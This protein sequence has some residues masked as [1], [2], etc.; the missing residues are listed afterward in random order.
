MLSFFI[1]Q[2]FLLLSSFT[3]S[4]Y[5]A[6]SLVNK[7][8][9]TS[10]NYTD[11]STFQSN[12]NKFLS[13]IPEKTVNNDWF[14]NDTIGKYPNQVYG[15]GMC[16]YDETDSDSCM[17]CL[18]DAALNITKLCPYSTNAALWNWECFIIYSN[19]NFFSVESTSS[20]FIVY[21]TVNASNPETYKQVLGDLMDKL[22][23]D[24]ASSP[25][26]VAV[27]EANFTMFKKVYGLVECTRDLSA[28]QCQKCLRIDI[29]WIPD[30]CKVGIGCRIFGP[31][32]HLR[33][34]TT[35]FYRPI[36]PPAPPPAPAPPP[37][38]SL[39][40]VE[41]VDPK[42]KTKSTTIYAIIGAACTIPLILLVVGVFLWIRRERRKIDTDETRNHSIKSNSAQSNE[43]NFQ[44]G[45]ELIIF[46]FNT[47][48][49]ATDNFSKE[50]KLGVGGFGVV[51]KGTLQN[52][53][54]LAVKRLS[55]T[56]DQGMGELR[57]EI[58]LLGRLKHRN[59]VKVIGC[60]IQKNEC[61][62]C[63]E[64]LRNSSLDKILFENDLRRRRE[65]NWKMRFNIIEGICRGLVYLHVESGA[66]II[67]RDL[68]ASNILLDE[69]MNPK[70]SDFGVARLFDG[71]QTHIS[72]IHIA[73]TRGYIAPEYLLRL[74]FSAKSDVFSFGVLILE[75]VTGRKCSS[76]LISYV[77]QHWTKR[78][79]LELKDRALPDMCLN[80]VAKCIHIGLLCVQENPEQRPSISDVNFMLHGHPSKLTPLP[81]GKFIWGAQVSSLSDESSYSSS[82]EGTV[83]EFFHRSI[84]TR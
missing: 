45:T 62:L 64:Y 23:M 1:L 12:L 70:I 28:L 9:S 66:T 29:G 53:Q 30:Y 54:E 11:G 69:N 41:P 2:S 4:T 35:P 36:P 42:G 68:K 81:S 14:Y 63:Y 39:P 52:K 19:E 16:Y 25:K 31:S 56:S 18:T 46:D 5:A 22:A 61:I 6:S 60:C 58:E 21:N 59:L 77:W 44:P 67:H 65:F 50:N 43:P 73:G 71:N 49:D 17:N 51:Y 48:R 83:D 80:E 15:L 79:V 78:K 13:S 84:H 3:T 47:L 37:P 72:T 24:V 10:N 75:I 82:T 40:P 55:A 8:C 33:Y 38:L 32:C 57:N 76:N 20:T 26:L 7:Y 34:E 27:G 74:T